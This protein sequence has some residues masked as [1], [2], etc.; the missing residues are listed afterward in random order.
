MRFCNSRVNYCYIVSSCSLEAIENAPPLILY[1]ITLPLLLL[2]SRLPFVTYIVDII[3][4][5]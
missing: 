3:M 2:P 1:T 4:G 5:A